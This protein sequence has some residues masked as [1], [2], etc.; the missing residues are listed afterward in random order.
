VNVR[1]RNRAASTITIRPVDDPKGTEK[2][3]RFDI[4]LFAEAKRFN[5]GAEVL[6][7][8][9]GRK[10]T[11]AQLLTPEGELLRLFTNLKTS[12]ARLGYPL[13]ALEESVKSWAQEMA[14]E[15]IQGKL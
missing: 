1:H 5:V 7:E 6:F 9:D 8:N 2:D 15:F 14:E 4:E 11:S 13:P 12:Y 3:Y 10:I